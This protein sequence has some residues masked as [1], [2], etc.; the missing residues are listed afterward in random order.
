MKKIILFS[1]STFMISCA[2][3]AQ[4]TFSVS[5]GL[6][7]NGTNIG[8][9]VQKFIPY[10]GFQMM[11]VGGEWKE[12]GFQ[13]NF[14]TGMIEPFSNTY[15]AKL[16]VMMPSL[17]LRYYFVESNKLKAYGNVAFSKALLSGKLEDSTDPTNEMDREF[18][19]A[20]KNT[21]FYSL[22]FGV[23]TE[24]FFD[25]QF[26]IGG[27]FG[28]NMMSLKFSDSYET[29]IYDPII[30]DYRDVT[31]VRSLKSG[32]RPTYSKI[33]LNFYFGK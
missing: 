25:E 30:D 21:K 8:Y 18:Q 6:Q 15:S 20:L 24:Y 12:D 22:Q 14:I 1:V 17:G 19:D 23:G 3:F 26:S 2:S 33:S 13:N 9:K 5:P 4:L 28:L 10:L 29:L 11:N 32:F 7:I 31:H 27:E 16:T